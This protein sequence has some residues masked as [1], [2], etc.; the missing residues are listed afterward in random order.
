M[1][2]LELRDSLFIMRSLDTSCEMCH[3]PIQKPGMMCIHK[4]Q[5]NI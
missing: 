4:D 3:G 5:T 1:L 2:V